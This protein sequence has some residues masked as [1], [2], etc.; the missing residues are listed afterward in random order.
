MEINYSKLI[1]ISYDEAN[2]II[3]L[4]KQINDNECEGLLNKLIREFCHV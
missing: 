2:K 4:L 3:L 1:P